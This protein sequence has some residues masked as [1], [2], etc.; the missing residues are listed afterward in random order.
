MANFRPNGIAELKAT[1]RSRL[2]SA[3]H[4]GSIIAACWVRADLFQCYEVW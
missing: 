1:A 3:Q 4:R 2:K